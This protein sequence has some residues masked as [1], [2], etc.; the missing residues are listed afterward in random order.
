MFKAYNLEVSPGYSGTPSCAHYEQQIEANRQHARKGL[1][2][3][4]KNGVIDATA[5]EHEW[6]SPEEPHVFLSHSH[7]DIDIA[8]G[9]AGALTNCLGIKCFIDSFVWGY[10]NDLLRNIDKEFCW[11]KD[12][13]FYSYDRRNLSTS[14]VHMMLSGALAKVMDRSECVI[15]LNSPKSIKTDDLILG[16]GSKTASPWI[17][18]ELLMTQMLRRRDPVRSGPVFESYHKSIA[19]K[20]DFPEFLYDASLSHMPKLSVDD[21]ED[22]LC[23]RLDGG[24]ALDYLYTKHA[25]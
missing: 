4:F 21:L 2:N 14:H 8:M 17:Y 18:H 3:F 11:L 12:K 20:G 25:K 24:E 6:F 13:G 22:W 16:G 9:I 10:A 1:E 7:A 15:F 19:S 5:L 23:C